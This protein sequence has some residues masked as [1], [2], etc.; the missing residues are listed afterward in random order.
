MLFY[1][2]YFFCGLSLALPIYLFVA[3][4]ITGSFNLIMSILIRLMGL[5]SLLTGLRTV[6]DDLETQLK[7]KCVESRRLQEQYDEKYDSFNSVLS[8]KDSLQQELSKV[9]EENRTMKEQVSHSIPNTFR[10]VICQYYIYI[11][12]LL[13]VSRR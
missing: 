1:L 6:I 13:L 2:I 7:E 4:S 12:C 10:F 9:L 11:A 8:D 5:I 3:I